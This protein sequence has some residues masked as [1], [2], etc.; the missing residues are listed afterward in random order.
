MLLTVACPAGEKCLHRND[1]KSDELG[2][3]NY[4][5]LC[6]RDMDKYLDFWNL[7]AYDYSGSWDTVAGHQSNVHHS[8]KN[9]QSTPFST[10][11]AVLAYKAAGIHPSKIVIGLPLYGRAFTNTAGLGQP[12]QGVGEG[13]WE[14]GV[15]D[16]KALPKAGAEECWDEDAKASYSYDKAARTLVSYDSKRAAGWKADWI[17]QEH[18]GGAMWWETSGDSQGDASLITH[19]SLDVSKQRPGVTA[20]T[21]NCRS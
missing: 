1:M 12:F 6:L 21:E 7:M 16:A 3:Q 10:S 4:E 2:A 18:L 14:S 8:H 13:S 19:V 11:A 5:K 15:W 17:K 20:L 9:P